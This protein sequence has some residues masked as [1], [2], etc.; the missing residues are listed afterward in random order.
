MESYKIEISVQTM[1]VDEL[2][3]AD[4]AL[5]EM[6][7]AMTP[8]SY[9]PYSHFHVGAALRLA[10]GSIYGGANQENAAYPVGTCA[11]R[12]AF[13][14][15]SAD[16]PDV[17][18]VAIAIAAKANGAFTTHPV[19]PCGM[20]RQALLEAEMR[21]GRP[22]RVLLFTPDVVHVVGSVKD[23]LPMSFD[24]GELPDD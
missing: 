10:D 21:H 11:E 22:M 20:C 19:S 23:L 24:G 7:C 9:A 4:R 8:K 6:A 2:S 13:F 14:Y 16:K 5:V 15:A 1:A 12:S 17:A 18:P 3:E